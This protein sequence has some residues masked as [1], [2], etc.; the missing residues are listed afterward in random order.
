M[1]KFFLAIIIAFPALC[2]AQGFGTQGTGFGLNVIDAVNNAIDSG[3]IDASTGAHTSGNND[4]ADLQIGID[5]DTLKAISDQLD[6]STIALESAKL[7]RA[8]DTMTGNLTVNSTFDVGG[9]TLA[10]LDGK[11]GIGTA[12]PSAT[13]HVEGPTFSVDNSSFQVGTLDSFSRKQLWWAKDNNI[14]RLGAATTDGDAFNAISQGIIVYAENDAGDPMGNNDFS[15]ARIKG[16]RFA[17]LD[18]DSSGA[19]QVNIFRV[20]SGNMEINNASGVQVF[21]VNRADGQTHILGKLGLG[22][23]SPGAKLD[24]D[25]NA[26]FGSG[27][28]KSTFT[29]SGNL[30]V[31]GT[32][33]GAFIVGD[34]SGLTNL[35]VDAETDPIASPQLVTVG[36]DT[37]TLKT[38]IDLKLPLAGGTMT[39]TLVTPQVNITTIS[40]I[41]GG[42]QRAFSSIVE[43]S[44]RNRYISRF[45]LSGAVGSTGRVGY[46]IQPLNLS[47]T[48]FEGRAE[49]VLQG[50]DPDNFDCTNAP[51]GT[52]RLDMRSSQRQLVIG[53]QFYSVDVNENTCAPIKITPGF[54]N[55]SL[56]LD[57]CFVDD[58]LSSKFTY[59]A[60]MHSFNSASSG[61]ILLLSTTVANF[62]VPI[63]INNQNIFGVNDLEAVTL[64]GALTGAASDNVLK[65][66]DTITGDL[67]VNGVVGF[68][69]AAPEARLEVKAQSGADFALL[70]SSAN[71]SHMMFITGSGHMVF[72]GATPAVSSC[73]TSP[74]IAGT[75]NAAHITV[76][77][78]ESDTCTITFASPWVNRPVCHCDDDTAVQNCNT[79]ETT[80]TLT[81]SGTWSDNEEIDFSCV[82]YR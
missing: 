53:S 75:D 61:N 15:F 55:V 76:G 27:A 73:G 38:E 39:G 79:V 33:T 78:S 69:E 40:H 68:G 43:T 1:M 20:D 37:D 54:S 24:V 21:N 13:L 32:I 28:T 36:V 11:V 31:P 25:G 16:G 51:F 9:S 41:E 48:T 80:T 14:F 52:L 59:Q 74:S 45:D 65:T 63:F 12:N 17:L 29:A 30:D 71:T 77:T 67:T 5:T 44:G 8:G 72:A 60:D 19:G 66:G 64:S 35:S 56:T 26:Q 3:D 22:T 82:G 18:A 7:D 49:Y 50:C 46:S 81:V 2:S 34:G 57:D 58:D 6:L 47:S 42:I 10:V 4:A 23:T 70:V 62:Q